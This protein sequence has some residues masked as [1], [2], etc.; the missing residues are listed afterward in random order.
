MK[1]LEFT[2]I[3]AEVFSYQ[4][5]LSQPQYVTG[6]S[7]FHDIFHPM[8]SN[9]QYTHHILWCS[10]CWMSG[11]FDEQLM[12]SLYSSNLNSVL[13]HVILGSWLVHQN[14]KAVDPFCL[15]QTKQVQYNGITLWYIKLIQGNQKTKEQ[16]EEL[17]E[18]V[19]WNSGFTSF[20]TWWLSVTFV[21]G[22][23]KSLVPECQAAILNL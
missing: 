9:V 20:N 21:V 2:E 19:R 17:Q 5:L 1:S 6:G 16:L 18:I 10:K 23:K 4:Y 22:V 7:L 15:L 12:T 14:V 13:L 8:V 3:P 11:I